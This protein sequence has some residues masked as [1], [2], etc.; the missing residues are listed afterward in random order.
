MIIK[1]L[2]IF[3]MKNLKTLYELLYD[4]IKDE[5]SILGLCHEITKLRKTHVISF[6]DWLKLQT[7]FN[8]NKPSLFQHTT[9]YKHR[10][11]R[12]RK[13]YAYWW[14]GHTAAVTGQRKEFVKYLI[15]HHI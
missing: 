15:E 9:F 12:K 14:I 2:N 13:K 8:N 3:K 10:L 1:H 6:K 11:F 5:K 4:Q 7:N